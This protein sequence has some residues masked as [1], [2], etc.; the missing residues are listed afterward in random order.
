M[1]NQEIINKAYYILRG[2]DCIGEKKDVIVA[3]AAITFFADKNQLVDLIYN[4]G[5]DFFVNLKQLN[6]YKKNEV[7]FFHL[8]EIVETSHLKNKYIVELFRLFLELDDNK[9]LEYINSPASEIEEGKGKNFEITNIPWINRLVIELF[10]SQNDN[11]PKKK[12]LNIEC[13]SGLFIIHAF[14]E[15]VAEEYIGYNKYSEDIF[16]AELR[17]E[18]NNIINYTI[19][20]QE[21]LFNPSEVQADLIYS[22]YPFSMRNI[23]SNSEIDLK[24]QEI[25]YKHGGINMRRKPSFNMLCLLN[26][27]D[28]LKNTGVMITIVHQGALYNQADEEIRK[29]F[30]EQDYLEAIISLPLGI[31]PGIRIPTSLLIFKKE[32]K[33]KQKIKVINAYEW[34]EKQRRYSEFSDNNVEQIVSAYIN[35]EENE[36]VMFVTN[37]TIR[38]RNYNLDL[39]YYTPN[40]KATDLVK[41]EDVIETIFRGYQIKAS[42]L[43]EIVT[44]DNDSTNYRIISVADI[45]VE[46]YI[47]DDLQA[48]NVADK[49]KFNKYCLEE[50]D[51]IIT[52][53]NTSVKMAVYHELKGIKTVL[54]GNLICIRLNQTKCNPYY[55][56]AYLVSKDGE[57]ALNGIQT[58]TAIKVINPKQLET[59]TISL[60]DIDKQNNIAKNY[61]DTILEIKKLQYECEKKIEMLKD[62]YKK[63][64]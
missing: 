34:I 41:L 23:Y 33:I 43:D 3:I 5:E 60:L 62:I 12:L 50:G 49:R 54:S 17:G 29:Y 47:S 64:R 13:G 27:L 7:I 10:K 53:K 37:D 1:E 44:D 8:V 9:I 36:N 21:Y 42:E 24:R 56:Q 31:I 26:T 14:N 51:L 4:S 59:M 38:S 55:L 45:Q 19:V 15:K 11:I 25:Q 35:N 40:E 22:F 32:K 39:Q 2:T 30:V 52:A 6:I 63:Q 20:K 61:K 18:I 28:S 48:I 16:F 46:G 58:G 57:R